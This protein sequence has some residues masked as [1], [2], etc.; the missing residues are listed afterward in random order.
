[1]AVN[2]LMLFETGNVQPN[3]PQVQPVLYPCILMVVVQ[4]CHLMLSYVLP[5]HDL[6]AL[7]G[8]LLICMCTTYSDAFPIPRHNRTIKS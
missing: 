3:Q 1:M 2:W 8:S 4:K 5:F 7:G 6:D